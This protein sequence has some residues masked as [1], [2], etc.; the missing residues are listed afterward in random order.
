MLTVL[1]TPRNIDSFGSGHYGA[2]RGSRIHN[3]E[4]VNAAYNSVLLSPV[5][6]V[7]TKLGYCYK[8]D[9][10]YRYVQ[11]TD[12]DDFD[13][14]FF[15]VKPSILMGATVELETKLGFVQNLDFRY[16]G[17]SNHIHLEI[18][19][20]DGNFIDPKTKIDL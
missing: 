20:K 11:V 16:K 7:V 10:S 19:D 6:G 1:T 2:S 13:W 8:N 14:R 17:I 12:V 9:A 3:G 5:V 18:K 15:Y 4:D